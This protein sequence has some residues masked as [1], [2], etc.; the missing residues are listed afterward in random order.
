MLQQRRTLNLNLFFRAFGHHPAAWRHP[1]SP[2]SG[3]PDLSYWIDLARKA[4]AAKFDAVFVAD[5][6]GT[7][8]G[9]RIAQLARQPQGY[10]FEPLTLMT[11]VAAATSRIG[12]VA[13]LSANFNEPFNVARRFAS[14]DHISGGRAGWNVVAS[15]PDAAA[16]AFGVDDPP[17]HSTRYERAGE[18]LELVKKFWDTWDDDAFAR[19]N[20]AEG[21]YLDIAS[22]HPVRHEGRF[23]KAE[24]VLDI[25]RPIQGYPVIVQAGNSDTGRAF[26]AQIAEMVYCS[27]QTLEGARAFYA[28]VK[29]RLGALWP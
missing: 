17:D 7:A 22:L 29:G 14:L 11:A 16:K 4:E 3:Q 28:D 23:Y 15:L 26:A 19:P 25:A 6:V 24:G 2:A 9:D 5:F 20:K 13:T 12:L 21:E 18:F 1:D 27:S 10:Q 8:G